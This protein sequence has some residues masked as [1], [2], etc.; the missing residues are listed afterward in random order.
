MRGAVTNLSDDFDQVS[1]TVSVSSSSVL[2]GS[3]VP[4]G[5]ITTSS[6]A[7]LT[8]GFST[9]TRVCGVSGQ[10]EAVTGPVP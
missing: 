2:A 9:A 3:T 6:S 10:Y 8:A 5:G 1:T 4:L 7:K